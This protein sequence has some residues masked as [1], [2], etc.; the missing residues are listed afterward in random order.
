[1]RYRATCTTSTGH[2][3][4]AVINAHGNDAALAGT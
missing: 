3:D 4:M 2:G 1:M